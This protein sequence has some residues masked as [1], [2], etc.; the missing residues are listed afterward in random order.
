M[1][2]HYHAAR[3]AFLDTVHRWFMFGVIIFG[4][5]AIADLLPHNSSGPLWL[6]NMF[7]ASAALIGALDLT[8]DL[9][10]RARTHSMMKR[11]YFELLADLRE[12][13]KTSKQVKVCLE[14]YSAEEEPPYRVLLLI[15]WNKAQ[16]EVYGTE[17]KQFRISRLY[18]SLKNLLRMPTADF[19]E[20][21]AT[22]LDAAT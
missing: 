9:S 14:R 3:E 10:N 21:R 11:R 16:K 22:N 13:Q 7:A 8:F 18:R 1:N 15:C 2:A 6:K 5:A 4:A 20:P 17:A 12:D 19:G